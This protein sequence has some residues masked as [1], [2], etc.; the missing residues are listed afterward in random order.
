MTP[1][2]SGNRHADAE[3]SATP[4]TAITG[5]PIEA[6]KTDLDCDILTLAARARAYALEAHGKKVAT[7]DPL[8]AHYKPLGN[9]D[10]ACFVKGRGR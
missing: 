4:A 1:A 10:I 8:E 6:I 3:T 2:L 9:R 5:E 7:A